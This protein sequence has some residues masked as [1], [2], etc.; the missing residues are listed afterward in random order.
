MIIKTEEELKILRECGK[1]LAEVLDGVKK[2]VKPGVSTKELDRVA[3]ALILQ[4][5]GDPVFKGY[6]T[7]DD[8]R[9]FP[10]TLCVS[11][12]DEIVHGIPSEKRILQEGDIV[13]LDIGMRWPTKNQNAKIKNQNFGNGLITDMAVTVAV[14]EI[15]KEAEKLLRVTQESLQK[16][17]AMLKAG[18]RIGN[19]GHKIQ[20]HIE[21]AGFGAVRELVGHGVGKKLHEDPMIPNFG[22]RGIGEKLH[23]GQVIAIEPMATLSGKYAI[24]LDTDGWTFRTADGSLAAHFEH[25]VVILKDRAEVLT[26]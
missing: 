18:T 12:N 1:K 16:G 8:V 24:R 4:F 21:S 20:T 7:R 5:G 10:A 26:K 19:L 9:P 2:K 6:Q 11:I 14:G 23:E 13:G 3:E 15:S 22:K 25:T 17:I